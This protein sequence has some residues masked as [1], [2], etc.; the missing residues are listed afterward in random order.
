MDVVFLWCC[1]KAR[2]Q[3]PTR[4]WAT[5]VRVAGLRGSSR[6]GFAWSSFDKLRMTF[7]KLRMTFDKL[8]MT[9]DKLRMTFDKLRMT[10]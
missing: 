6:Q 8:R 3:E 1:G 2:E 5:S 9:F 4:M 7:D 10:G